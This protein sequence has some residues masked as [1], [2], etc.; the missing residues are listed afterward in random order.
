ME[1][2]EIRDNQISA[3]SNYDVNNRDIY[4]RLNYP[5]RYWTPTFMDNSNPWVQIDLQTILTVDGI[6]T[7]GGGDGGSW[8]KTF[9]VSYS[10]DGI[11]FDVYEQS[12]VEKVW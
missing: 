2:T 5:R 10:N 12:G 11:T 9:T 6:D 4:A 7:Q 3:S 8:V 1:S